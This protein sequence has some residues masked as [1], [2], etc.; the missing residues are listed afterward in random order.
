MS[1]RFAFL[2]PC[3]ALFVLPAHA[4][5]FDCGKA[6]SGDER[7]V[8]A[9]RPLSD[10]DV[11]MAVRF[12]MMTGLVPMGT[13]GDMQDAQRDF[14]KNRQ[15]CGARVACL[16]DLYRKRIAALKLDYA[17]LKTRGPF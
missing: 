14:L 9:V 8:C 13:R 4:A 10:M 16:A 6:R 11:E 1:W 3:A 5:S 2:L 12:E 17:R 7:A 15:R